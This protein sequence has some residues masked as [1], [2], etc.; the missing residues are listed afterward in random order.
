MKLSCEHPSL[1]PGPCICGSMFETRFLTID[2]QWC[3]MWKYTV[4]GVLLVFVVAFELVLRPLFFNPL[5][6]IPGPK[7]YALTK[8]R[9]ALDEWYGKRTISIHRL[10]ERYGPVIRIGPNEVHFNSP[11][12]MRTIYGPGSGFERTDFYRMFDAYGKMNVCLC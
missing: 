8:W 2:C 12:A 9:L 10:H 4:C 11:T 1:A 5:S 6:K 3:T 7:L